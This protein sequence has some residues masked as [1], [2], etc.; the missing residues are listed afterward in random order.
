MAAAQFTVSA[1]G[2]EV[3]D[4]LAQQLDVLTDCDLRFDEFRAAWGRNVLDLSDAEVARAADLLRERGFGVSAVASPIGK[5][6]LDQPRAFEL[7]RLERAIAVARALGTSLIR[8]FSFY[9]EPGTAEAHREEVL[10]RMGLLAERA[11]RAGVILVHENERG[12]Y[13]DTP[14]RCLDVLSSVRSPALRQTFDPANFVQAGVHPM[15]D[16]WPI[17]QPYV[18][19]VHIKDAR[20]ADGTVVPAGQG[21][22]EVRA[23]LEALAREGYQGYLSLEPHLVTA[24]ISSGYSAPEGMRVASDALRALLSSLP[25]AQPRA[26]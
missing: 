23:L 15:R 14:E 9:V 24:G 21:D 8:V 25:R 20:L 6:S 12:I 3:A 19:H 5:S 10:A 22:G 13:G 16:A 4:D 11:E 18:A 26:D 17:L 1:F 7:D 2:D